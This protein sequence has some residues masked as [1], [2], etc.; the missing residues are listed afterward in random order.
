MENID[1]ETRNMAELMVKFRIECTD[2]VAIS[3]ATNM[4]AKHTRYVF[5]LNIKIE[6][7]NINGLSFITLAYIC[8]VVK[9]VLVNGLP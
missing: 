7:D 9:T 8:H 3:D 6:G 2:I 5:I 4:P 1:K